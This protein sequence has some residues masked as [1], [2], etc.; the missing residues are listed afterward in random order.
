MRAKRQGLRR[1]AIVALGNAGDSK[2]IP[3]LRRVLLDDEETPMLRGHAAWALGRFRD[4]AAK[5][6]LR[7]ALEQSLPCEVLAEV[8]VALD[9]HVDQGTSDGL[10][11]DMQKATS[12]SEGHLHLLRGHL[13]F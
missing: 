2:A 4:S 8:E 11:P 7:Q 13:H 6:A 9:E 1:N 5:E 12:P 10:E 3:A